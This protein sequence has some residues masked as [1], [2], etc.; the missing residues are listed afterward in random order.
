MAS[1]VTNTLSLAVQPL[2]LSV[3]VSVYVV[4]VLGL[5]IGL[6]TVEEDSPNVGVQAYDTP[7]IGVI[8]TPSPEAFTAH[9][10]VKSAPAFTAGISM[11]TFTSI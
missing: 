11:S 9:V 1:T 7:V 5:A 6:A 8:P 4:V 2:L 3:A 10:F